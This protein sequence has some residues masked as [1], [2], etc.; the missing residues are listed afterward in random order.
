MT[1]PFDDDDFLDGC[2]LDFTENADDEETAE[3]RALF[4]DGVTHDRWEEV[5]FG[6]S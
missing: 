5:E 1:D 3:L 2:E 4:P 6:A